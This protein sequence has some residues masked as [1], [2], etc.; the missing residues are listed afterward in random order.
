MVSVKTQGIRQ[1]ELVREDEM[2]PTARAARGTRIRTH[3]QGLRTPGE[4]V[5]LQVKAAL[6]E[7]V[8][9]TVEKAKAGSLIHTKWLWGVVEKEPKPQG[10]GKAKVQ[11]SLAAL[12]LEQ[13]QETL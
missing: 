8:K 2:V 11:A 4:E 3:C 1:R 13:L 9:A 10:I 6:P 7:I 5:V 12:L